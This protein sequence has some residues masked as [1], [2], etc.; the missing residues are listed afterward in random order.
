MPRIKTG[1][2]S[3]KCNTPKRLI[4]MF[5]LK[6][7]CYRTRQL[8]VIQDKW[9]FMERLPLIH[10]KN[11]RKNWNDNL[12]LINVWNS[13]WIDLDHKQ[14]N[15]IIKGWLH[16][17]ISE[18]K[19]R[20]LVNNMLMFGSGWCLGIVQIQFSLK[21]VRPEHSLTPTPATSDNI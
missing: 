11:D 2:W 19:G 6:L 12:H 20:F 17:L 4:P 15:S 13:N 14:C 21:I 3:S 1:T 8:N 18:S 5:K 10:N 9:V 16:C 7:A